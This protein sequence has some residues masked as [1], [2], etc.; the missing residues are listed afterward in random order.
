[1]TLRNDGDSDTTTVEP[2]AIGSREWPSPGR[3]EKMF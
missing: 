3:M 2:M 1:M